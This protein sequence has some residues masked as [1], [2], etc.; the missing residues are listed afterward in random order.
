MF[1]NGVHAKIGSPAGDLYQRR[2]ATGKKRG[3][4]SPT[5][6]PGSYPQTAVFWSTFSQN[7][8]PVRVTGFA[9]ASLRRGIQ[10][11]SSRPALHLTTVTIC[12]PRADPGPQRRQEPVL[13]NATV[14]EIVKRPRDC[15]S[16][17]P[18]IPASVWLA[19][20]PP[21]S[22]GTFFQ[23]ARRHS[24]RLSSSLTAS[25]LCCLLQHRDKPTPCIETCTRLLEVR[26]AMLAITPV[27][28]D[29]SRPHG[30]SKCSQEESRL[31]LLHPTHV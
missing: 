7:A 8:C 1:R 29:A 6:L 9:Q 2:V 15:R 24:L 30:S 19:D 26:R 23:I 13:G 20:G 10:A 27:T 12:Q 3:P 16:S 18:A 11:R 14:P 22:F 4:Q 25:L 5:T 21:E 17:I 31:L 28:H